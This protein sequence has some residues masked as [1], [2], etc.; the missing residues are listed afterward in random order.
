MRQVQVRTRPGR[1]REPDHQRQ[2]YHDPAIRRAR[3]AREQRRA[4]S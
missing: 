1:H 3:K 4:R 2:E